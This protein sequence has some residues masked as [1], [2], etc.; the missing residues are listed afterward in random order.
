MRSYNSKCFIFFGGF[1]VGFVSSTYYFKN[2]LGDKPRPP[3]IC[4]PNTKNNMCGI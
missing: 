3:A 4:I 2:Y 1:I